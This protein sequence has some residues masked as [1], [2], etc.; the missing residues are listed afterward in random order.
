VQRASREHYNYI[1]KR[2]IAERKGRLRERLSFGLGG[3]ETY[4]LPM[5]CGNCVGKYKE[6]GIWASE[7]EIV[8]N[9]KIPTTIVFISVFSR[10]SNST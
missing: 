4:R 1:G 2:N 6:K 10:I 7:R 3:Q 5:P 9:S 8:T